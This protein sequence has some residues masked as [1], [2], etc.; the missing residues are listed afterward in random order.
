MTRA[1]DAGNKG[2][3][4]G[5][6]DRRDRPAVPASAFVGRYEGTG[7]DDAGRRGHGRTGEVVPKLELLREPDV[8]VGQ[9]RGIVVGALLPKDEASGELEIFDG[10][11]G[12]YAKC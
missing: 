5:S 6:P 12:A 11:A 3:A 9:R 4:A 1:V 10:P 2:L 8:A 7:S